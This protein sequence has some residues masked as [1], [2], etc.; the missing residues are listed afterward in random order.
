MRHVR[1]KA[2]GLTILLVLLSVSVGSAARVKVGLI[3][4]KRV[5]RDAK[6]AKD[7]R[8][9]IF[10]DIKEKQ[11]VFSEKKAAVMSLSV[12]LRKQKETLDAETYR[13]KSDALEKQ[14]KELGRLKEDLEEELKEK[15]VELTQKIL[16][17]VW[18][19][20]NEYRKDE[21]YTV[22]FEADKVVSAD[23]DIDITGEI[24][25]IYDEQYK[26]TASE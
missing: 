21:N 12:E 20:V 4:T 1:G 23:E 15:N 3:D 16:Q 17:E 22:I 13:E 18:Q 24:I 5:I 10:K 11:A 19:I 2:F 7:A 9:D 6:A 25:E 8:D 14:L 26:K